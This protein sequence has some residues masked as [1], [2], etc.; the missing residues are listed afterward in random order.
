MIRMS[1]SDSR[2]DKRVARAEARDKAIEALIKKGVPRKVA[3]RQVLG[4]KGK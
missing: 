1:C 4:N 3:R 2:Q